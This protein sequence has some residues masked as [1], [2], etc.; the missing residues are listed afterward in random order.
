M[1][2][3]QTDPQRLGGNLSQEKEKRTKTNEDTNKKLQQIEKNT[4]CINVC[5]KGKIRITSS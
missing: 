5:K 1:E 4:K 3:S 2:V